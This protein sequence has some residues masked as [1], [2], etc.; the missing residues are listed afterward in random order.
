MTAAATLLALFRMKVQVKFA[1]SFSGFP[2]TLPAAD[3]FPSSPARIPRDR[4]NSPASTAHSPPARKL[5]P[6]WLSSALPA[7][8]QCPRFLDNAPQAGHAI[9][10][11]PAP[12]EGSLEK[13]W[14]C[15]RD[16]HSV[17]TSNVK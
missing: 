15:P 8:P 13:E 12:F 9:R 5:Y 7:Q 3:S 10:F 17:A 11:Q 1:K 6:A 14:V 16:V 2:P 4:Q